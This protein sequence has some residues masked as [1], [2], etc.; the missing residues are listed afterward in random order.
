MRRYA[1]AFTLRRE[2]YDTMSATPLRL[3]P[4]MLPLLLLFYAII[5][6]AASAGAFAAVCLRHRCRRRQAILIDTDCFHYAV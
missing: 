1:A 3:P 4:L 6:A 5:F 2:D